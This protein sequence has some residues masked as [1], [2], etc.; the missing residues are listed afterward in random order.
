MRTPTFP[1]SFAAV[2]LAAVAL[3]GLAACTGAPSSSD[4][5][6]P[7]NSSAPGDGAGNGGAQTTEEACALVQ[8]TITDVTTEFENVGTDDPAAA[9]EAMETAAQRISELAPEITDEQVAATLPA[10]QELFEQAAEVVG[11]IVEGDTS[12]LGEFEELGPSMQESMQ[13][14]QELCAPEE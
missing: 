10:L 3:F 2:T 9:V 13:E 11:A 14:F 8:D 5:G 7:A 12:K 1:R 4:S 6:A